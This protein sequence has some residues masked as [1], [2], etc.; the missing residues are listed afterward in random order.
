MKKFIIILIFLIFSV[1]GCQEKK[2]VIIFND[3]PFSKDNFTQVKTNFYQG[4]RIYYL[5]ASPYEF[6]SP[7]IRVQVSTVVDKVHTLFYKPYW[8]ADYRLMKDEVYYYTNYFV[9]HS[10]G[11]FLVQIF[12]RNDLHHPLAFAF[13]TVN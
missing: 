2:N 12:K 10:K 3:E 13:F 5:F 11:K 4:Q 9:I 1:T 6:K 7:Y 8:A